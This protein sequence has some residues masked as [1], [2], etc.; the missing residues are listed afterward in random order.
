VHVRK[1]GGARS[2]HRVIL[3]VG[4]EE[5]PTYIIVPGSAFSRHILEDFLTRNSDVVKPTPATFTGNIN[6]IDLVTVAQKPGAKQNP[7]TYFLI[8]VM[9]GDGEEE[10]YWLPKAEILKNKLRS[11]KELTGLTEKRLEKKSNNL[12]RL[13]EARKKQLH[14]VTKQPLDKKAHSYWPWLFNKDVS[15]LKVS[16]A[17]KSSLEE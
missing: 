16:I 7:I 2:G 15:H 6:F 1:L 17:T 14:P 4:V 3:D 11:A 8:K 10:R 13:T 12:K 5:A 9:K